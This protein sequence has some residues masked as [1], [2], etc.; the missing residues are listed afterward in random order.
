MHSIRMMRQ[1]LGVLYKIVF[2]QFYENSSV[3][4]LRRQANAVVHELAKVATS[5]ASFHLPVNPPDCNEHILI[6]EMI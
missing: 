5:E 2:S 4:F 1:N 3:E 6:N